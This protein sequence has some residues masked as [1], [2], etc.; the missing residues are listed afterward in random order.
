[1]RLRLPHGRDTRFDETTEAQLLEIVADGT[2]SFKIF[3]SYKNFFGV[4]DGEM[5]QTLKL[6]RELGVIV[7]AHCENAELVSRLQ[8]ELIAS[9]EDRPGVARTQ[10]PRDSR[11]GRHHPLRHV[12]R[13]YRR[14]RLCGAPLV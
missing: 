3:L 1:M 5:Y 7:T 12:P 2:T 14:Q 11:G 9:G 10:P 6:A 8:A 13:N 4:D